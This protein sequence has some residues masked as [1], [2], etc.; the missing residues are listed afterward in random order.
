MLHI[1]LG[2]STFSSL[3]KHSMDGG[4]VGRGLAGYIVGISDADDVG[5]ATVTVWLHGVNDAAMSKV[6]PI[7]A[8][9]CWTEVSQGLGQKA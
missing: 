2:L 9:H 6:P 3:A 7:Q 4:V 8:R 1:A 5:T